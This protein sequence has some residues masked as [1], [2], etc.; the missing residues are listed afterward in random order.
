MYY[1][2][3]YLKKNYLFL[4]LLCKFILQVIGKLF[5]GFN[6]SW[7]NYS[8]PLW[9]LAR[10]HFAYPWFKTYHF[11]HLNFNLLPI[12]YP[13]HPQTLEKHHFIKIRT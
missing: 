7:D 11:V 2:T 3:I 9:G 6:K 12:R 5:W 4:P 8:K 1:F 10:L 13:P